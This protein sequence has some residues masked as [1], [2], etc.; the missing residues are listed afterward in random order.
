MPQG[1]AEMILLFDAEVRVKVAGDSGLPGGMGG[2]FSEE[3][4]VRGREKRG[5]WGYVRREE[6]LKVWERCA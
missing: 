2:M 6:E 4:G 5:M 3:G 1:G